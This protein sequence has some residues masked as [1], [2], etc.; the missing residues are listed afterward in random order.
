MCS[1]HN[2][3]PLWTREIKYDMMTNEVILCEIFLYLQRKTA[4]AVSY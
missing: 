1:F 2:K 3:N 4:L